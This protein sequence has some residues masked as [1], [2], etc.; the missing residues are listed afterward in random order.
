MTNTKF[1][2]FIQLVS[3]Q[4]IIIDA[5][6]NFEFCLVLIFSINLH[7]LDFI[8]CFLIFTKLKTNFQISLIVISI[9]KVARTY[10]IPTYLNELQIEKFFPFKSR[11]T[12]VQKYSSYC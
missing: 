10:Q 4:F 12:N 3:Q 9:L 7:K 5:I 11:N 2:H 1:L 6:L 8:E